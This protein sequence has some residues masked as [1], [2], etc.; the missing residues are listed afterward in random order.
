MTYWRIQSTN[1]KWQKRNISM[2]CLVFVP[3]AHSFKLL[4]LYF[5]FQWGQALTVWWFGGHRTWEKWIW[6]QWLCCALGDALCPWTWD[7][8]GRWT[9]DGL[10]GSRGGFLCFQS[11]SPTKLII[12]HNSSYNVLDTERHILQV[13]VFPTT[14]TNRSASS[15][16]SSFL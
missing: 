12:L 2:F 5:C 9:V 1:Q 14:C 13:S 15:L 7:V 16:Q 3:S 4:V 11:I 10:G 8:V 6:G